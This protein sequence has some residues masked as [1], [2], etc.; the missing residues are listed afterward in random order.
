MLRYHLSAA[1]LKA[2]SLNEAT[3]G[4]YRKLGNTLG[5]RSRSRG[6]PA[7]YITRANENLRFIEEHGAIEN[8]HT[9]L[10]IGTGWVHWESLFTRLFYD[11]EVI[12]FDV[13]DNR[14]FDAFL[15]YLKDLKLKLPQATDRSEQEVLRALEL[16]DRIVK[17][18]N[19]EQVYDLL[20]FRYILDAGGALDGIADGEVDLAISSDVME[21]I[22]EVTL[23]RFARSL[24]RILKPI[25][26]SSQQIVQA[27]HLVIYDPSAHRKN[28]LRYSNRMW[29]LFFENDVQHMNRWQH[30]DFVKLYQDAGFSIVAE[31]I[32]E[33]A[34]TSSLK[35]ADRW[36]AYEK[37]DL[38]ICVSRILAKNESED[39]NA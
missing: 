11:V 8:G 3:M 39:F 19:F 37:R 13:W 26:M 4:M 6:I 1:A 14:Q 31:Q 12:T 7:H 16:V 29:K 25:G 21:H 10:E 20:G 32:V 34:D 30:S 9:V 24:K 5:G 33:T 28:Y 27:D 23:S 17:C 18:R 38:D 2:F 22:P 36:A 35:I 15:T